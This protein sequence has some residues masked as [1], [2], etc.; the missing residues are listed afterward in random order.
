MYLLWGT[1][2]KSYEHIQTYFPSTT[3]MSKLVFFCLFSCVVSAIP[4][5]PSI[6]S[7]RCLI[8]GGQC[9]PTST[10][11][12]GWIE[13]FHLGCGDSVCCKPAP[14][15]AEPV[16]DQTVD[17][18]CGIITRLKSPTNP[19][20]RIIGGDPA[21]EGEWPWQVAISDQSGKQ[22]C[23]G[24]LVSP[25]I[26]ISAAH[27][28]LDY[29]ESDVVIV[30]GEHHLIY[31]TGN[32]VRRR[33][34][35]IVKHTG[36][37]SHDRLDDFAFIQLDSPVDTSGQYVRSACLPTPG[38][39]NYTWSPTDHCYVTGWGSTKSSSPDND[40]RHLQHVRVNLVSQQQCSNAWNSYVNI[41]NKQVCAGTGTIGTCHG[42]SGGPLVCI[43]DNRYYLVGV[44]SYGYQSCSQDG[45]P[46]VYTRVA[47]YIDW[48]E[49]YI[50][51]LHFAV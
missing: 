47:S 41:T 22:F 26:V 20:L 16:I 17:N 48:M 15:T 6:S 23:G 12:D 40:S 18:S 37:N 38:V 9:V 27:C 28:F 30:L 50:A 8:E 11:C 42:D 32:E 34:H 24:T 21:L 14:I 13:T 31:Q 35:I 4:Q 44:T 46:D 51:L 3:M 33:A 39:F 5:G 29:T 45:Y 10:D 7:D 43:H 2:K 49:A 36:Y 1:D 19:L 25:E